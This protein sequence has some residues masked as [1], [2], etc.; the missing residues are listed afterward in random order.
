[1]YYDGVPMKMTLR[2]LPVALFAAVTLL[3]LLLQQR[4]GADGGFAF[5]HPLMDGARLL[6]NALKYG[7]FWGA[8]G[9]LLGRWALP[10]WF[11]MCFLE[12]AEIFARRYYN[13]VLD[14][15]W[16][17][18]VLASSVAE[19]REMFAGFGP[20]A[21]TLGLG[22]CA[23]AGAVGGWALW[24]ATDAPP[25]RRSVLCGLLCLAPFLVWNVLLRP[26][27]VAL[28]N[29]LYT[30]LPVDTVRNGAQFVDIARTARTPALPAGL[31]AAASDADRPFGLFV[32]GESATRTHWQLYGYARPTTPCLEGL[33]DELMV[34]RDVSATDAFT[35]QSLRMLLTEAT[36]ESPVRTRST[37]AQ[38]LSA[39]GL[40]SRLI[41]A[42]S[43]WGRW[44]GPETLLFSGCES[45]T[46]LSERTGR[47]APQADGGTG[48]IYDEQL[49]PLLDAALA[50][51][52]APDAVFLHLMGSHT[53]MYCRYPPRGAVYPRHTGDVPPGI[54]SAD[55]SARARVDA[56]DNSIRYTDLVL[57]DLV[58]R[59]KARK[60][61]SFLLYLSDHGETPDGPAWRDTTRPEVLQVPFVVWFS[62]A[63][64]VT[65]PGIVEELRRMAER[66]LRLDHALPLLRRLMCVE[67]GS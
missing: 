33:R 5:A 14:G 13:M 3:D 20:L 22:G 34:F 26:L 63:Y 57:D 30:F 23:L 1:M 12:T 25:T 16:L 28:S 67:V 53:P 18:L 55:A 17:M 37:F 51:T 27:D 32:I 6:L 58:A 35:G 8:F 19:M 29:T 36:R 50:E 11:W 45:K 7:L 49:L 43:R 54:D 42:Q 56:Y 15:D 59:L 10:L 31:R 41:S 47:D 24:K 64:R 48:A 66:P 2:V 52:N 65:H 60:G 62:P 39:V 46:Y 9:L 4:G 61:P 40:R 21:V 44:E 38:Q